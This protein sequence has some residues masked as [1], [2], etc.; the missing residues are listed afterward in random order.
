MRSLKALAIVLLLPIM[1]SAQSYRAGATWGSIGG[2]LSDQTDLQNALNSAGGGLPAGVVVL[3]VSGSCPAGFAEETSLSGRF[4][5]GTVAANGDIGTTG[6]SD[7][8]TSVLNHTH[9]VTV[10]DPGHAH[11][12]DEGQTDGA[13]TFM[14]RSNA[15]SATTSA[16]NSATTGITASTANPAGGVASIDNRPAFTRV[17]WCKKT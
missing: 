12:L 16:T 17:I 1:A 15:A 8:I 2:T 11:G 10:T 6:G 14:D 5:L 3:V 4:V 7:T 13:G 9:T